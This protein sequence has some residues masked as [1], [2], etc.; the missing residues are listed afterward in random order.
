MEL[1]KS[2]DSWGRLITKGIRG[3]DPGREV[4]KQSVQP[5]DRLLF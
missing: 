3:Y 2:D 4:P 5:E 1:F